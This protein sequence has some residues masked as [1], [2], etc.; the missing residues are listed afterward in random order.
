MSDFWIHFNTGLK[1]LLTFHAYE[2]V[3]F[4]LVLT[5]P[6]EFKS[7]KRIVILIS[8]L[9]AAHALALLLSVFNIVKINVS[10]VTFLI[11]IML[12]IASF[13]NIFV[14]GKSSKK[15]SITFIAIVTSLFGIIH[16][17]GFANYFNHIVSGKPTDKLLPLFESALGFEIS[18]I[19]VIT[20]ALLLAYVVQTLFKFTKRDWILIVSSFVIG[21]VI[22]MIIRSEIWHK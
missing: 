20:A 9:T 22:P 19:I 13:Y 5:V 10:I 16:G 11:P 7:W 8:L 18:Q 3:L 17:L 6:Y 12:L 21:I 14:A 4:L 2:D 15:D 1:H